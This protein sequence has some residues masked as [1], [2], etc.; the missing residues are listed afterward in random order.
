MRN[1]PLLLICAISLIAISA[2]AAVNYQLLK[3]VAVP[4]S[5]GWDYVTVDAVARRIYVSHATQV[6]VLDADSFVL[7]GTIPNTLG[8]HG[9]AVAPDF[10]RGYISAGKADSVVAFDLKTL[11]SAF[12]NQMTLWVLLFLLYVFFLLSPFIDQVLKTM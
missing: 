2:F 3:K 7:V 8:V 10:G 6:D 9:I 12:K 11:K 1:N 4:G 5:G